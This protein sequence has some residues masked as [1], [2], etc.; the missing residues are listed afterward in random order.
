MNSSNTL[1]FRGKS[2]SQTVSYTVAIIIHG[3]M[4]RGPDVFFIFAD[5]DIG[6]DIYFHYFQMLKIL[7]ISAAGDEDIRSTSSLHTGHINVIA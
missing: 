1:P 5:V 7:Q 2:A 4:T 6:A 3:Y